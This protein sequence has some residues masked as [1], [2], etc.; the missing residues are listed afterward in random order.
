MVLKKSVSQSFLFKK[1]NGSKTLYDITLI[2][3]HNSLIKRYKEKKNKN[4]N[5]NL[6]DDNDNDN[7][8]NDDSKDSFV[9]RIAIVF[10]DKSSEKSLEKKK[11]KGTKIYLNKLLHS[12]Y[13]DILNMFVEGYLRICAVCLVKLPNSFPNHIQSK[14]ILTQYTNMYDILY[15]KLKIFP[16]L[17]LLY[18]KNGIFAVVGCKKNDPIELAIECLNFAFNVVDEFAGMIKNPYS[19]NISGQFFAVVETGGELNI[20]WIGKGIKKS[21]DHW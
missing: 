2:P 5:N 3:I 7:N 14:N 19:N 21:F 4:D 20:G 13:P 17:S 15:D 11:C 1:G 18:A 16:L 10:N 8:K 12:V 6:D 9:N